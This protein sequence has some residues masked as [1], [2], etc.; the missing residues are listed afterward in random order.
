[1]EASEVFIYGSGDGS[2]Q[3]KII[4]KSKRA[5]DISNDSVKSL[6]LTLQKPRTSCKNRCLRLRA[7][8]YALWV[9][10]F[11]HHGIPPK[12]GTR[13]QYFLGYSVFL[14]LDTLM[15][16]NV[17]FHMFQPLDNWKSYGIPYFFI[18]PAVTVLGPLLGILGCLFASAKTLKM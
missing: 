16:M 11:K 3:V 1:M 14:A 13:Y 9:L 12:S 15:T 5:Y 4:D 6:E 7:W 8:W 17:C 18:S 2:K 10:F